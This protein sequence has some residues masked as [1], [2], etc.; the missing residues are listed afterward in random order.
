M[1]KLLEISLGIVTSIGGFLEAG[2][3]A[4]ALQAGAGF[5]F[6][7][8]WAIALGTICIAFLVEMSGRFAAVSRHTI[9]DAIRERFGFNFFLIPFAATLVV[10]F[11][12]LCA[13][14]GG[15][16]LALQYATGVS[17]RI[18]GLPVG[19]LV[20]VLL[21]KGT[22]GFIEKGVSM[23]GL[24]T[25][26][27]VVAA[28]M[29]KP[30]WREV[31][32]GF[33][34]TLPGHDLGKYLFVAVSILGA[35]ISPYLFM[36]YSSGAVEDEWDESYLV[37][38]RLI[39]GLGMSFGGLV[40]IAALVTAAMVFLPRGITE[41]DSF[42]KVP[43]VL[44]PVFGL[45][46]F[47]LVVS[48]LGIACLGASLELSLQQGYLV[49]QGFG[50]NWGEDL[51]PRADPGFSLTYT[52]TI[53]VATLPTVL[54]ADPMRVTLLSTSLTALSVPLGVIPFLFL[55]NDPKYV[56]EHRNGWIGNA[57]VLFIV[58][59]GFVLA[60]VTLPLQMFGS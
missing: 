28:F 1:K 54:G 29:L 43:V 15:I 12:L 60:L 26:C 18:W 33:L 49:A 42:D 41:I 30:P 13:E 7:L 35:S 21:W 10:N 51:P 22:F 34:P 6:D 16:S 59:L 39:A 32:T 23:L 40:G 5:R 2:S 45:W 11:A 50:W 24:I 52:F 9:A 31:A 57:A 36:F 55:M 46:G 38:N 37:T 44:N 58:A 20:W 17:C 48:S 4:T 27:F 19:A 3:L 14:I 25:L 47:I 8:I 56:G 53:A